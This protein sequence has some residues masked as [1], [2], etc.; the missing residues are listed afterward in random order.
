MRGGTSKMSATPF[1]QYDPVNYR[2]DQLSFSAYL[3]EEAEDNQWQ[4]QALRRAIREELTGRQRE[5]LLLYY[6]DQLTMQQ[7]AERLDVNRSPSAGRSSGERPVC[8]GA[9]V[10]G[11]SGCCAARRARGTAW[12]CPRTSGGGGIPAAPPGGEAPGP[13]ET[14]KK[15]EI[16]GILCR[17]D[18]TGG[19]TLC[20]QP[21][22]LGERI[23]YFCR[24][25]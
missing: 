6:L 12:V 20:S 11:A 7:V 15:G 9:C 19:K 16:H 18:E 17:I 14:G 2:L 10:T 5:V 24:N 13:D 4:R 3:N 23:L 1:E 22:G 21:P 8:V 25:G